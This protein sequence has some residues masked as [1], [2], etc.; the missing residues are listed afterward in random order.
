MKVIV[1][2]E[3]ASRI[4]PANRK[5]ERGA[6]ECP[7]DVHVRVG[8][9][10]WVAVRAFEDRPDKRVRFAHS[11]PVHVE[12]PGKPLRPRRV[13]AEYFVRRMTQELKRNEKVLRPAELAEYR[14]ALA[15]YDACLSRAQQN[16]D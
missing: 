2:G 4:P 16:G 8:G 6:Y 7:I 10:S 5:T 12:V 3:V 13:E 15:A 1:N 9:S 14:Q 11:G